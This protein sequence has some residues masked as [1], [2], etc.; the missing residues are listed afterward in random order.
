MG[1]RKGN[2]TKVV[3]SHTRKSKTKT[4]GA[5]DAMT[6]SLN[7]KKNAA[8]LEEHLFYE[9]L[10]LRYSHQK[11]S[12]EMGQLDWNAFMESFILHARSLVDFLSNKGN[13]NTFQAKDFTTGYKHKG[14]SKIGVY[15]DIDRQFTHLGLLRSNDPATKIGKDRA[16]I[17][18]NWIEE[19]LP[20]FTGC[21]EPK[22]AQHWKPDL[23]YADKLEPQKLT[24]GPT[25]HS[26]S[27][28]PS[29]IKSD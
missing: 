29:F 8:F 4:G 12:N 20:I 15:Q 3:K 6:K 16:A 23:A 10:M 13:S 11:I 5:K 14:K 1:H 22:F 25:G 7:D 21:L 19:A 24:L 28:M 26:A 17:L 2:R 9:L 27:S 18:Y